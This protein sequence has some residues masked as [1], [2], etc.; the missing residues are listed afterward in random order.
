MSKDNKTRL[1]K[2]Y[3][4]WLNIVK[5]VDSPARAETICDEIYRQ[6][7]DRMLF[8]TIQQAEWD[9]ESMDLALADFTE[10]WSKFKKL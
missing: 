7:D 3:S 10:A 1:R 5:S 8:G 9:K 2:S 4:F 6:M